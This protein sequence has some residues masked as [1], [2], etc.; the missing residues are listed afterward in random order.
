MTANHNTRYPRVEFRTGGLSAPL[1]ARGD[2]AERNE[3]AR[4]DLTR[5][6]EALDRELQSLALTHAEASLLADA[7]NGTIWEPHTIPLLWAQVADA[8]RDGALAD[9]WGVHGEDFVAR[10]RGLTY[11]QALSVIDGI[12]KFWRLTDRDT[13]MALRESGLTG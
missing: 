5:Y 6:Y 13:L 3:I 1:A 2:D 4:R 8:I 12:E 7:C 11:T 10:L 9:K